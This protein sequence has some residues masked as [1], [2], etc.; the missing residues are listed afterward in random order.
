VGN[1]KN[2]PF[3]EVRWLNGMAPKELAPHLFQQGHYRFRTVHQELQIFN[4][5]KNIKNIN[6]EES[7]DEFILLFSAVNDVS[8]NDG[9]DSIIWKWTSNDEYS[10]SS[11]YNIQLL[12]YYTGFNSSSIWQAKTEPK[13]HFFAWLA[14]LNKAP[15]TDNLLNKIGPATQVVLSAFVCMSLVTI[16]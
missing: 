11:A 2:T 13:Y 12:G 14:L 3:C 6:T 8:L 7:M 1:G 10:A 15:T 16:Y 9:K 4:W 5:I